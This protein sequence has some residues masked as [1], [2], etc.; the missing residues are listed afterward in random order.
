MIKKKTVYFYSDAG[1]GWL[2]VKKSELRELGIADKISRCSY[3][4]DEWAYLEEDCDAYCYFK[5]YVDKMGLGDV[6]HLGEVFNVKRK[7][8]DRS[9]KIRSYWS[10]KHENNNL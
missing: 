6:S 4:R 2:K 8:T 3:M 1:H 7:H 10:Y 5:A 9:S